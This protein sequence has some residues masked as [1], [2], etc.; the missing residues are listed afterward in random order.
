M[1]VNYVILVWVVSQLLHPLVW[2]VYG[3]NLWYNPD[4]ILDIML[5]TVFFSLPSLFIG[6]L[7]FS[8]I[9]YQN[10]S[11]I[12]K[13]I[14]C[15]LVIEAAILLTDVLF[16]IFFLEFDLFLLMLIFSIPAAISVVMAIIIT[17]PVFFKHARSYENNEY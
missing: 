2:M 10:M 17:L 5:M 7:T 11:V 14:I 12:A 13:F 8:K 1:R 9:M 4:E 15:M 16:T 3:G 6:V